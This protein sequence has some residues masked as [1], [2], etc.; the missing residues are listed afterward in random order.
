MVARSQIWLPVCEF[1]RSPKCTFC[2]KSHFSPKSHFYGQKSILGPKCTSG[3]KK[4]FWSK[5]W[6]FYDF[7]LKWLYLSFVLKVFGAKCKKSEFHDGIFKKFDFYKKDL[8]QRTILKTFQ[9][10]H[11][12]TFSTRRIS[13]QR[14]RKVCGHLGPFSPG[15]IFVPKMHFWAQKCILGTKVHFWAHNAFWG[16]FCPL[17]ADAYETNCFCIGI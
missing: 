16:P 13:L 15:R 1:V 6:I 5:K 3:L 8:R 14:Y 12:I 11:K 7:N 4:W 9:N 10:F 2:S 17:A